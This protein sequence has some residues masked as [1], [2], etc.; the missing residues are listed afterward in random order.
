M[1]VGGGAGEQVEVLIVELGQRRGL[2]PV[3]VGGVG[4][5]DLGGVAFQRRD[6]GR[7]AGVRE[8]RGLGVAFD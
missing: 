4:L 6:P 5:A 1:L 3:P 2:L 7:D 8:L